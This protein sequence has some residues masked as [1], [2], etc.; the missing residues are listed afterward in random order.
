MTKRSRTILFMLGATVVNVV[1]MI[2]I[3]VVL[4]LIYGS[5]LAS[6]ISPEANQIVLIVLFLGSIGLTYFIYHRIIKWMQNKWDLEQ[7]FD[8]IFSNRGK[9]KSE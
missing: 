9:K 7:Y 6:R 5:L 3:F 4:F 8:P 1:L 2:L